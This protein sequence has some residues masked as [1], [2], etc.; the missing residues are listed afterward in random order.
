VEI[1]VFSAYIVPLLSVK[2]TAITVISSVG[3]RNSLM[4][5][6]MR[7][8][9]IF[10]T[11]KVEL[12]CETCRNDGAKRTCIHNR[13]KIP[14]WITSASKYAAITGKGGEDDEA[15]AR[16]CL[17][18]EDDEDSGP[19]LFSAGS[20][21]KFVARPPVFITDDVRVVAI[22]VDPCQGS[23]FSLKRPSNFT[24]TGVCKTSLMNIVLHENI[25]ANNREDYKYIF[26]ESLYRLR[27]RKHFEN[28]LFVISTESGTGFTAPDVRKMMSKRFKG[29][30]IFVDEFGDS[31]KEGAQTTQDT[32]QI[33]SNLLATELDMNRLV[34]DAELITSHPKVNELKE[35]TERQLRAFMRLVKAPISGFGEPKIEF[36]GKAGGKQ[37]DLLMSLGMAVHAL[38]KF[39]T[40]PKYRP[41]RFRRG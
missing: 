5:R 30:T 21:D 9:E 14:D 41:Y 22:A 10:K 16:E 32:K 39:E 20:V 1:E 36:S 31:N 7:A 3:K 28:C 29:N 26:I 33:M 17:G 2:Y 11:H 27:A 23:K 40:E 38:H 19:N 13:E 12:V 6:C 18:L 25:A 8:K 15:Y 37:D 4:D 35:E 24:I 34:Y